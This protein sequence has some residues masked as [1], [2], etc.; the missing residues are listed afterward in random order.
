PV[1]GFLKAHLGFTRFHVRGHEQVTNE[2][3][4]ALMAVNLR[5]LAVRWR[6]KSLKKETTWKSSVILNF[7]MLFFSMKESFVSV[8]FQLSKSKHN[9]NSVL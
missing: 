1:F 6:E 3:G 8:S 5:K 4:L 9:W 7:S 2:M